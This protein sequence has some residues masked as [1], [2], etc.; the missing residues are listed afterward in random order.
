MVSSKKGRKS[1]PVT[2]LSFR[3]HLLLA[4]PRKKHWPYC[5]SNSVSQYSLDHNPRQQGPAVGPPSSG[6]IL[7]RVVPGLMVACEGQTWT[8]PPPKPRL[9]A[10]A[11]ALRRR[12]KDCS[13]PCRSPGSL[14]T[15]SRHR[16]C[17][18]PCHT[19]GRS[20]RTPPRRS[21]SRSTSRPR[22]RSRRWHS[23]ARC[24]TES[25]TR[26]TGRPGYSGRSS[27]EGSGR[28]LGDLL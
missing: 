24:C 11:G 14:Q 9:H 12:S 26:R 2:A 27:L 8:W 1:S 7:V 17:R 21:S 6:R 23:P 20:R 19:A 4:K 13:T 22:R 16:G 25:E 15:R 5:G 28:G 10:V 18:S 3:S